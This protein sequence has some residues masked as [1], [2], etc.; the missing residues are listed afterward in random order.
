LRRK[1]RRPIAEDAPTANKKGG[2]FVKAVVRRLSQIANRFLVLI[3]AAMLAEA[4]PRA[5]RRRSESSSC[6][7]KPAR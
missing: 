2:R 7:A 1:A 6:G 5:Q 3:A 4:R